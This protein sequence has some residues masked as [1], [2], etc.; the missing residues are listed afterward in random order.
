M[1]QNRL[2][3]DPV[4]REI[5]RPHPRRRS[6]SRPSAHPDEDMDVISQPLD[7]YGL[8]YYMPTRVAAGPGEGAVPGGHG[9]G[10]GGR[11]QRRHPGA[12]FHIE[13]LPDTETTAYGW[14]VK[15]EY[16]AVALKEMA[17]RY[18]NLPPVYH[19]RGRGE[20]RGRHGPRQGRRPDL[21]SRTSG[22]CGTSRTTSAPPSGDGARRRGRDRWTCAATTCGPSWTI[23]SGRAATSSRSGWCTWT[24]R[25]RCA[26]RRPP[27]TGSRKSSRPG[28]WQRRGGRRRC[29]CAVGAGLAEC[30][31]GA[32]GGTS[33]GG[34]SPGP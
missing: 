9:G 15:P 10:H 31:V 19:H 5:P 4:L 11:P 12:P 13:P 8:N 20:L 16:M 21:S 25:P 28:T 24:S 33:D 30:G 22:A 1:A 3:A 18:P 27:S 34:R 26:R 23:S 14:P 6:S 7:F 17:E 32:D 29:R 2:Y